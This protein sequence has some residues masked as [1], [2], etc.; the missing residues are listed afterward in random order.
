[1]NKVLGAAF[2]LWVL[3]WVACMCGIVYV[4]WHFVEKFW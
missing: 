1:M 4:V 2:I 3:V